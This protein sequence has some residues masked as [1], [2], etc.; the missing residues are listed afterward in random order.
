MLA[1]PQKDTIKLGEHELELIPPTNPMRWVFRKGEWTLQQCWRA[2][3]TTGETYFDYGVWRD[4]PHST[5][6]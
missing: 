3:S 4:V 1:K 5:D 2:K 6:E